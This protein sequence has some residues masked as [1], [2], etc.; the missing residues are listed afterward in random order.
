MKK[1]EYTNRRYSWSNVNENE[2]NELG[3]HGWELISV[4]QEF[5]APYQDKLIRTVQIRYTFKREINV[6]ASAS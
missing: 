3:A 2:L 1:F 4:I 5:D 6:I